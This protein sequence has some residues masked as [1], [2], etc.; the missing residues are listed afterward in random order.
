MAIVGAPPR[1]VTFCM[2]DVEG[3]TRLWEAQPESMGE[4]VARHE[5]LIAEAVQ[6]HG[7]RFV[8]GM[9][10][11]DS[12]TSVFESASDAVAAAVDAICALEAEPWP[13]GVPIRARFGLHTGGVEL[14]DGVYLGTTANLTA[15]VRGAGAGGEILL[16]ARTAALLGRDLPTGYEIIDLGPHRLK[17][18]RRPQVIKA[19]TGP[20]LR[21]APLTAEGPYR[22][23][24][25][26]EAHHR[27]LFFGREGVLAEV[28]ARIEPGRL[29]AAHRPRPDCGRQHVR[30]IRRVRRS[31]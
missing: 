2:S 19:L 5:E 30:R 3:S 26:F 15:R 18:I 10:E 6:A 17:G 24:L 14:R 28:L 20:G 31:C 25:P 4:A 13:M 11:G 27:H 23:L 22:G 21:T 1:L 16:S 7:G 29:V 9:G 8:K 12:T